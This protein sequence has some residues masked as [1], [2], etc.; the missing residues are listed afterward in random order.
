MKSINNYILERLNP[1]HLGNSPF[2]KNHWISLGTLHWSYNDLEE[3]GYGFGKD[4]FTSKGWYAVLIQRNKGDDAIVFWSNTEPSE[5]FIKFL[6]D[7]KDNKDIWNA[8]SPDDPINLVEDVYK[9]L[10][11]RGV[12]DYMDDNTSVWGLPNVKAP[13]EV[14]KLLKELK[15]TI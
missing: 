3:D 15:P 12:E 7:I 9:E 13:Q 5:M 10:S 4:D 2:Q 8:V 6:S 1:R 11:K 14:L